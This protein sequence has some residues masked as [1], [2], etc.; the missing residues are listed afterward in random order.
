MKKLKEKIEISPIR[1]QILKKQAFKKKLK[2]RMTV[3]Y[4]M[5]DMNLYN[6]AQSALESVLSDLKDL[7]AKDIAYKAKAPQRAIKAAKKAE[8]RISD[9]LDIQLLYGQVLLS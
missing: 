3:L 5:G 7:R 8:Q 1:E 6:A 4:E 2:K 9:K